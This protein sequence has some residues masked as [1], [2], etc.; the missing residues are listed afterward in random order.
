MKKDHGRRMTVKNENITRI[1]LNALRKNTIL[2]HELREI[3]DA[4]VAA[5]PRDSNPIRLV[6]RCA[7]TSRPRN[8]VMRYRLSRFVFREQADHNLLSGVQRASGRMKNV[9]SAWTYRR[10]GKWN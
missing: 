10:D 9:S 5:L 6:M 8:N 7:V 2:P 4:E 1:R 3:A